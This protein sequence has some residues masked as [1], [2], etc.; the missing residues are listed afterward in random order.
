MTLRGEVAG[1]DGR[2][3]PVVVRIKQ[4]MFTTKCR[5]EIDGREHPLVEVD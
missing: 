3:R 1:R 5:L 2:T 4:G